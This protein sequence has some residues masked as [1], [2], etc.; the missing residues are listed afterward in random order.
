[1]REAERR[2]EALA[3]PEESAARE[4]PR[5]REAIGE[6]DRR[7]DERLDV[8]ERAVVARPPRHLVADLGRVPDDPKGARRWRAAARA[9][10]AYRVRFGV[11]DRGRQV[12]VR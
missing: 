7:I 6:L 11:E 8:V 4:A 10:E 1:M 2:V 3:R 5:L 12:G 9:V